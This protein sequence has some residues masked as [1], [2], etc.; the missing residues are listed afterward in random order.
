MANSWENVFEH[1]ESSSSFVASAEHWPQAVRECFSEFVLAVHDLGL[2]LWIIA[3]GQIRLGN[4]SGAQGRAEACL[5]WILSRKSGPTVSFSRF[6]AGEDTPWE[7]VGEAAI[8]RLR[9]PGFLKT[10]PVKDRPVRWPDEYKPNQFGDED[11]PHIALSARGQTSLPI[12][13]IVAALERAGF[14]LTPLPGT[15]V[16]RLMHPSLVAPVYVKRAASQNVRAPLVLHPS[17]ESKLAEWSEIPGIELS[18]DLYYH[19]SNLRGFP[20]RIHGGA[21]PINYGVALG[22]LN[23]A[24]MDAVVQSLLGHP[25][26]SV[27]HPA[28]MGDVSFDL[29]GVALTDTERDALIKARVGQGAYRDTLI[30]YWRGCSVTEC[31]TPQLL[32]ASHIKPW[33]KAS[34]AER[35]DQFNGLLLTPNLDLAFDQGLISFD[36]DGGILLS[37][38]LDAK[39]A[40]ALHLSPTMKLRQIESRHCSYLAWHR[41]NLFRD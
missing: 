39:A 37:A 1:F 30:A 26:S 9:A 34:H 11:E 8:A 6:V 25:S 33:H 3:D 41:E 16:F 2:D 40:A 7:Q 27:Q 14:R 23:I 19:N 22:F 24:A 32:R 36:D 5:A 20:K 15:K 4:Y 29:S 18:A 10:Y 17:N 21:A 35:L 28:T 13:G 31:S 12:L 38:D